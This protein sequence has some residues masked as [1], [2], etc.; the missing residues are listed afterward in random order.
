[1]K[2][3]NGMSQQEFANQIGISQDKVSRMENSPTQVSMEILLRIS[4]HFGMSLDELVKVPKPKIPAMRV[5]YTWSSSRATAMPIR[6][7]STQAVCGKPL[8]HSPQ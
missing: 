3:L 7:G 6:M 4:A 5:D 2:Q 8:L 1:M